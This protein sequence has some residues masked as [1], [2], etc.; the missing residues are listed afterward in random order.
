MGKKGIKGICDNTGRTHF[1]KGFIPW[2]KGLTKE[3]DKRI[4]YKRPTKFRKGHISWLK[5]TKGI[6]K[7]N[8]GCFKKGQNAGIN[9]PFWKGGKYKHSEGYI[10][11]YKPEHPF[12]NKKGKVF[13]HRLIVEKKLGRYLKSEEIVHHIN[14]VRNDN[15]PKNLQLFPNKRSHVIF[16][17]SK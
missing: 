5:N 3:T 2:N 15:R 4:N 14:R 12:A 17:H 16:H 7:P 13:E 1:K 11:I 9:S 8:S 6:V 10:Y